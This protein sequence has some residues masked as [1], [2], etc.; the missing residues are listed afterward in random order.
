[1]EELLEEIV[2]LLPEIDNYREEF[3]R[4]KQHLKGLYKNYLI[5][6]I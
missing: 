2:K 6:K 1:M 4:L 3:E 5:L